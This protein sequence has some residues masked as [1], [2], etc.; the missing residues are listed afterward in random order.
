MQNALGYAVPNASV[1]Y[2]VH[3]ALTLATVYSNSTSAGGATTDPQITNGLAPDDRLPCC[4]HV[5][6]HVLGGTD[7]NADPEGPNCWSWGR[8]LR[9]L[10][11]L[12]HNRLLPWQ[13]RLRRVH[14]PACGLW[15]H[16]SRGIQLSGTVLSGRRQSSG[17]FDSGLWHPDI[18]RTIELLRSDDSHRRCRI[19]RC[20][21]FEA[22]ICSRRVDTLLEL[23]SAWNP[24]QR[25]MVQ[26]E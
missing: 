16:L 20:H 12:R 14:R 13:L 25:W 8:W 11:P 24:D 19:Q 17:G 6:H 15:A 26:S 18:C 22:S 5:H 2:Y 10:Q 7:P 3:R 9:Q 4:W 23:W 1:T 21:E